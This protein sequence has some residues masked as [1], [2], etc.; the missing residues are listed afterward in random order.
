MRFAHKRYYVERYIKCDCCGVLIY[1]TPI[2]ASAPDGSPRQFCSPWCRDWTALRDTGNE[3]RLP[4][5]RERD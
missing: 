5:P 4:L 2:A 1:D 3:L